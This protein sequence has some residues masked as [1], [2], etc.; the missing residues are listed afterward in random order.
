MPKKTIPCTLGGFEYNVYHLKS[1]Y[2]LAVIQLVETPY[3]NPSMGIPLI[4]KRKLTPKQLVEKLVIKL[5][6]QEKTN[7]LVKIGGRY[8]RVERFTLEELKRYISCIGFV[9]LVN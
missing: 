7:Y 4:G 9:S 6:K 8:P 2:E 1:E 3:R 5:E